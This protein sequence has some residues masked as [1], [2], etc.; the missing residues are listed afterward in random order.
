VGGDKPDKAY[1]TDD[2]VVEE[3]ALVETVLSVIVSHSVELI[4]IIYRL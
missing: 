3:G 4:Y 1:E 2:A